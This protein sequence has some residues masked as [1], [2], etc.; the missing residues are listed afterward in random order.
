MEDVLREAFLLYLFKGYTY[1]TPGRVFTG[2]PVN[3]SGIALTKPTQ[4]AGANWTASC[5]ITG[6]F[7]AALCRTAEFRSGYHVL[8][9]VEGRDAIRQVHMKVVET[10]LGEAWAAVSTDDAP[11]WNGMCWRGRGYQ[12]S[13]P[14]SIGRS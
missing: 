14:P 1:Q 7:I 4:T 12:R 10:A 5:V 2:L 9:M 8:L 11:E 3:Q 13:S 6:H